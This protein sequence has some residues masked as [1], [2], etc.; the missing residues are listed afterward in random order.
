M[1]AGETKIGGDFGAVNEALTGTGEA[2]QSLAVGADAEE[3][4]AVGDAFETGGGGDALFDLGR[5]AVGDFDDFGAGTADEVVMMVVVIGDEFEARGAVAEIE[6][7]D[8]AHFFKEMHGTINRGEIAF[9]LGKGG[10][11][12]F[13]RDRMFVLT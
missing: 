11:D 6:A 4:E 13:A 10:E 5:E 2:S 9:A 7:M 1:A 12:F 3:F 8:H